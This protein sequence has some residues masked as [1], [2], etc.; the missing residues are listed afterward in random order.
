MPSYRQAG[1]ATLGLRWEHFH[2]YILNTKPTLKDS[3]AAVSFEDL[4]GSP[5]F[6]SSWRLLGISAGLLGLL[7]PRL[8]S[9][10]QFQCVLANTQRQDM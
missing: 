7:R 5:H 4:A 1:A 6:Q 9:S 10:F 8:D 3:S 2:N